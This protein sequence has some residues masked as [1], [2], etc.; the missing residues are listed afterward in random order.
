MAFSAEHCGESCNLFEI[1]NMI[2]K[3]RE[4]L[5]IELNGDWPEKIAYDE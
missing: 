5:G 1:Y 4:T 2:S 3:R